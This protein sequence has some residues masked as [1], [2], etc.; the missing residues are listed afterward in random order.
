[1]RVFHGQAKLPEEFQHSVVAIGN[2]DG[3]H[4][5]HQALLKKAVSTAERA[6]VPSCV[7]TF[8]PHPATILAPQFAPAQILTD[9]ERVAGMER[10]GIELIFEQKFDQAFSTRSPSEFCLEV[11]RDALR[12]R[13]VIIGRDFQFGHKGA[14]DIHLMRSLLE[15]E[16]IEI[17]EIPPVKVDGLDCSSSKIRNF[18]LEGRID[19]ANALLGYPYFISGPV[20]EGDARGRT[21]R[22]PTANLRTEREILPRI[23]VYATWAILDDKRI[24]SV[25]NIGVRPTFET[26]DT[27]PRIESHLLDFEGELY[28]REL[29][30]EFV[31]RLRDELKFRDS[32]ALRSQIQRDVAEA[33]AL[34]AQSG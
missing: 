12:V 29:R 5:G 4:L 32:E 14:G 31:G 6:G 3:L 10:N 8:S 9:T 27:Q 2:F 19:A 24:R 21:M 28:D 30:V 17:I 16:G 23:G 7:L 1:M 18:L 25:T 15:P 20:V 26:G 34:L 11:L 22:V 13:A 33:R